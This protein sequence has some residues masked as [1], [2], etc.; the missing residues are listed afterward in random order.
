MAE[1]EAVL[2]YDGGCPLCRA[3]ARHTRLRTGTGELVVVDARQGAPAVAAVRQAGMDLDAGMALKYGGRYYH[4]A[5][6]L[7]MLAS[8]STGSGAFNAA[9]AALF[10][11]PKRARALYPVFRGLRRLVLLL[12]L[13]KP[14]RT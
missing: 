9:I 7:A 8:L 5:G 6:C 11:D 12:L 1:E 3:F 10:R 4:G 13:R 14:I 2:I